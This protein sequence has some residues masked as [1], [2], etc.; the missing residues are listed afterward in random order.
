M[1]IFGKD[2]DFLIISQLTS[3]RYWVNMNTV[4]ITKPGSSTSKKYTPASYQQAVVLDSGSTLS[5]LPSDLVKSMLV[6][7]TGVQD[8][9]NGFHSI[10]CSQ[11]NLAGTVDFGFGKTTIKVPYHR[12][13][14]L[15]MFFSVTDW[16]LQNSSGIRLLMSATSVQS[17][18]I[19]LPL[20]PGSWETPS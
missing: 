13:N 9:G 19:L 16:L 12:K 14:L 10:D 15:Y 7:F 6:D 20:T 4:G 5:Y 3:T 8:A 17:L 18:K 1:E 11:Y 2:P